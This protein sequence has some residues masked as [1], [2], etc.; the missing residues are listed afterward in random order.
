MGGELISQ[1]AAAVRYRHFIVSTIQNE[2]RSRFARSRI[3]AA[4]IVLH[5]L[6]QVAIFAFLL[7]A[8]LA[9]KLPGIDDRF[10]YA[11]Y[12][13]AG[14]LGWNLFS[15]VI[16]R[17]LTLF[18]EFGN[19]MKKVAFPRITLPL[20]AAGSAIVNNMFLLVAIIVIFGVLGHVPGSSAVWLPL[21][22]AVNV[23]LA[24]GL[25][26]VLGVLNVF[27]RDTG[28]V[29][30]VILQFLFWLSPIVYSI[31]IVPASYKTW[32]TYNPLYPLIV[33]YQNVL[34]YNKGPEWV[35]LTI[36]AALAVIAMGVALVVFQRASA[37]MVDLL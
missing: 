28:Q 31:G 7:S 13:M 34:L 21:L 11:L 8:V 10:A 23:A 15:E 3:G 12:L 22:M 14:M 18:I 19:T 9:T 16:L 35:G 26:I 29:V 27:I 33:S 5:P 36:L 6:A 37:E 1:V 25:G 24:L 17:C 2:I 32:L 20:I 30:P 4:W